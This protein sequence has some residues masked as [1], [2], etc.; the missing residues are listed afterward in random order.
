MIPEMPWYNE[1]ERLL[2]P[3]SPYSSLA[4]LVMALILAWVAFRGDAVTKMAVM[5]WVVSP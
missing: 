2:H 1:L 3:L 4:L 5:V